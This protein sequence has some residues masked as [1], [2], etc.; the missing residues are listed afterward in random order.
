MNLAQVVS[1]S[2]LAFP[3]LGISLLFLNIIDEHN[4]DK[5]TEEMYLESSVYKQTNTPYEQGLNACYGFQNALSYVSF[6]LPLIGIGLGIFFFRH[7][8]TKETKK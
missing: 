2:L 6:I 8:R 1:F 7:Y 3:L 4:C 5:L